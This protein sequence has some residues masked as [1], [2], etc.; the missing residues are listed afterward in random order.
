MPVASVI[1]FLLFLLPLAVIPLGYSYFEVPKVFI[2]EALT[3]LLALY[4][5][6]KN[7]LDFKALNKKLLYP[8]AAIFI[9]SIADLIFLR[10]SVSFFGNIY[11]LQGIFFLWNLIILTILA[12]KINLK[13]VPA[14]LYLL[15]LT[16]L[17][18]TIFIFGQDQSNRYVGSLGEA[19]ALA[20]TAIFIW[21]FVFLCCRNRYS[22]AAGILATIAIIALSSSRSGLIALVIQLGL[23]LSLRFLK[24]KFKIAVWAAVTLMVLSLITPFLDSYERFENR[25]E[26]WQ[27]ALALPYDQ[28]RQGNFSFAAL[29]W[30]RGIGNIE[31]VLPQ[32]SEALYNNIRFQYIDSAH[33]FFLDWWLQGGLIGVSIIAWF[34]FYTIRSFVI[35]NNLLLA[36]S[37]IGL[38][39]T[40]LFNPLSVV[41]L[42]Q[43]WWLIGQGFSGSEDLD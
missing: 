38:L 19:N 12:S 5:F 3:I 28:I 32:L 43:F 15:S 13:T 1:F 39:T 29:F 33:N 10:T 37:F 20:A 30:G 40:L 26:I 31:K 42:I 4:L 27:T 9:L 16:G 41:N 14:Y 8:L 18:A 2:F 34:V 17:L 7:R 6:I 22:Q 11:R 23:L 36:L 35:K 25:A 21:P 24:I